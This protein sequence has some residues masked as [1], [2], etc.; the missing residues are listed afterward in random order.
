MRIIKIAL[1]LVLFLVALALG[2][3]NQEVVTFNYLL[4]VG[5]FHLSTLIG[6]IF[7]LGFAVATIIFGS[8]HL[9][10]QLKVS[11]LNR[12]LKKMTAA[13]QAATEKAEKAEKKAAQ[14][15]MALPSGTS[16]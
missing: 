5:D 9:R 8:L 4:A 14:P 11:Q 16:K 1:V 15:Q 13:E 10:S 7:V 12:R 2:A 6:V 3:Q